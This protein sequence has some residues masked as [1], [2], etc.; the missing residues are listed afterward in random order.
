MSEEQK[1]KNVLLRGPFI[2]ESG[3]GVH[4]RQ[5]AKWFFDKQNAVG[6]DKLDV[7][8]ELLPWGITPWI[9]NTQGLPGWMIQNAK[10]LD[11]YDLSV[12]VQLPNEWNA[13]AANYN[14]GVTAGVE[15]DICNPVWI[16]GINRMDLVIVPSEFTKTCFVNTAKMINKEIKTNIVVIPESFTEEVANTTVDV[17]DMFKNIPTDFNFLLFGQ[18]TGNN[19][20]NDRKNFGYTMKALYEAF[21]DNE[22]VGIIVKTNAGRNTSVDRAQVM[23]LFTQ[24]QMQLKYKDSKGP[25]VYI[26]HG[27]MDNQ[28]VANMYRNP[29]VKALISLTR[30]EG[31]GLP[32]LEA[33]ASDLPV[34]ATD[35]SAHTE[36]LNEGKWVKVEKDLV[37]VHESRI[38]N[39]IFIPGS[40]WASAREPDAIAK[41]KKFYAASS[42]P[43]QWAKDLG[44]TIRQKYSHEAISKRYDEIFNDKI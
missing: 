3:Y 29:K 27:D 18:L 33:A 26:L 15:T 16:D 32:M 43:K 5:I 41:L 4:A 37:P 2:T 34:I 12:Q 36:F 30:G 10:K 7:S 38:D 21:K 44:V 11:S 13:F 39:Q 8:F 24:L 6:A 20:E 9:T 28:E 31:F 22:N 40:K 1:K 23:S 14:I 42:I 25:K 35:W 19:P 17:V